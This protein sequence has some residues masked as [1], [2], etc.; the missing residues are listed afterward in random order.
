[1]DDFIPHGPCL[2]NGT[3]NFHST[4]RACLKA[5][6]E[7]PSSRILVQNVETR[8]SWIPTF[9]ILHKES[10]GVYPGNAPHMLHGWHRAAEV[11]GAITRHL[12]NINYC[13]PSFFPASMWRFPKSLGL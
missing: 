5:A 10:N 9:Y 11:P 12:K 6:Q 8:N 4:T 1:M 13:P 2:D 7:Q 3:R